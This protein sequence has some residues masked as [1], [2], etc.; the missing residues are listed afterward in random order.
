MMVDMAPPGFDWLGLGPS[1]VVV[2]LG[3][4]PDF[5]VEFIVQEYAFDN[6]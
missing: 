5:Q 3:G 2:H 1:M 4:P 6:T